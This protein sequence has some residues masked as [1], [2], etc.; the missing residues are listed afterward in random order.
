MG[1]CLDIGS[2]VC[3]TSDWAGGDADDD[4]MIRDVL[5]DHGTGANDAPRADAPARHYCCPDANERPFPDLDL[6]T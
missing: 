2:W 3:L 6:A 5:N 1:I 4:R